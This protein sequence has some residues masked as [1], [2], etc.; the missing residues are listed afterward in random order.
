MRTTVSPRGILFANHARFW[1]LLATLTA[2][3]L[4][5]ALTPAP[6]A[7]G[8]RGPVVPSVN[9]K[10][11]VGTKEAPPFSMKDLDGQWTGISIDLWRQ[12]AAELNLSYEFRELDQYDLLQGLTNGSLDVVVT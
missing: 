9:K 1:V 5:A 8:Q 3:A 6:E 11:A 2:S 12:I 4:L 10:L 7:Y